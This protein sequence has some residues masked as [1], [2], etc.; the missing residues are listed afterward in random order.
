MAA[1]VALPAASVAM[2]DLDIVASSSTGSM[3]AEVAPPAASVAIAAE[4]APLAASAASQPDVYYKLVDGNQMQLSQ[5][6]YT[7]SKQRGSN[8]D[9]H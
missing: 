2:R 8:M 1:E 6:S 3:A 7:S 5:D 4:A 9:S